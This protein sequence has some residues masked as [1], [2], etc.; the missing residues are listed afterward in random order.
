MYTKQQPLLHFPIG[1]LQYH[2]HPHSTQSFYK[3][4]DSLC[5]MHTCTTCMESHPSIPTHPSLNGH[6]FNRFHREIDGHRFSKWNNM[7]HSDKPIVLSIL[8][9][10]KI[11]FLMLAQFCRLVMFMVD[12]IVVTRLFTPNK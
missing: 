5:S 10:N 12:N 7:D 2:G 8:K 6:I 9:L 11:S 1:T 4:I 3:K